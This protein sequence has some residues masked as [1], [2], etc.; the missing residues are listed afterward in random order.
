[1]SGLLFLGLFQLC[2]L[3]RECRWTGCCTGFLVGQ[4]VQ[5]SD[6]GRVGV[7]SG[8]VAVIVC[9][10]VAEHRLVLLRLCTGFSWSGLFIRLG[11][12]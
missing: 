2:L 10:T 11:G 4:L 8:R 3:W 6:E 9:L 7:I 12:S 5:I 1:M